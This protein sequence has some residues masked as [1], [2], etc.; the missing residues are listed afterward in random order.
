MI[1]ESPG[2]GSVAARSARLSGEGAVVFVGD[3]EH[4]VADPVA[5]EEAIAEDPL[6][7]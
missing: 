5:F 1:F 4:G 3:A 2:A 6:D 7:H